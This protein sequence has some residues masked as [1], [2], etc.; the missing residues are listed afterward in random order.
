MK[1]FI[2]AIVLAFSALF[3]VVP[4]MAE[5]TFDQVQTLIQKQE[6]RAAEKGLEEIIHNHPN[7]AKAFYAMAQAQAGLGNLT[8]AQHA[9]DKAMGLNPELSFAPKSSVENL[10]QAIHPQVAKIEVIEES[11]F[12]HNFFIAFI[13]F[14]GAG[15]AWHFYDKNEKQKKRQ[16]IL[17]EEVEIARKKRYEESIERMQKF[18]KERLETRAKEKAVGINVEKVTKPEPAKDQ[19]IYPGGSPY[20]PAAVPASAPVH[21]SPVVVNNTTS[22]NSATDFMLGAAMGHILTANSHKEE[23]VERKRERESSSSDSSWDNNTKTMN[24]IPTETIKSSSWDDSPLVS[25]RSSSW[26]DSSSSSR[27]SSWDDDSS[28]SRSSSWS[29]SSDSSSSSWDSGSS[30]SGSSS[31]SWD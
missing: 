20:T 31:S 28:S 5:P 1:N 21:T 29:S 11:H 7:S 10:K 12:W 15:T 13:L 18:E 2:A 26:D 4:A 3:A 19:R 9:L 8:K 6:Y 16:K 27:S 30:D 14:F 23:K 17:D 22:N 25:T 24:S